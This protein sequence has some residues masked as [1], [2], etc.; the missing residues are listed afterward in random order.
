MYNFLY[1]MSNDKMLSE[2]ITQDVFLKLMKYRT[3][4]KD[5]KFVS[6]MF[7]IARN[8]LKSYYIRDSKKHLNL[9]T[10][11]HIESDKNEEKNEDYSHLLKA[12]NKLGTSD[13]ELLTLNK[14]QEIKYD[15]L[16]EML[17]STP[18]A[19]KTRVNRALQKLKVIYFQ[20][21]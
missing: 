15:E 9:D 4:Y 13:K 6:W 5:G 14:L 20:N 18:G 7:T 3:T 10:T 19:I 21:I 2:D 16:A 17:N 12:L 11:L 8:S 1:Q